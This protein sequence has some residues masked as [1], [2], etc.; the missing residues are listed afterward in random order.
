[1]LTDYVVAELLRMPRRT[2]STM[3]GVTLGVGLF[4]GVLFFVDGLSASMTQRA[5]AP[6][7][8][9]M[10]R[11]V[12]DRAG[13]DLLLTQA[14]EPTEPLTAGQQTAVV[15]EIRND[16]EF[17]ANEVTIRSTPQPA[18]IYVDG[19]AEMDGRPLDDA[20]G[21]PFSRGV[22]QTGLNL[23]R[24]EAGAGHTLTYRVEATE[25]VTPDDNQVRTTFSTRE[26]F[27]PVAA[28]ARATVPLAELAGLIGDIDGVHEANQLSLASLGSDT[29]SSGS[30]LAYGPV[31]IFGFDSAYA[32]ADDTIRI[33]EGDLEPG[34]AVISSEAARDLDIGI[35]DP[36]TAALPDGSTL[37]RTVTGIADLS[38]ARSL[39]TSRRGGD[40]ETFIYTRYSIVVSPIDFAEIVYPAYERAATT[41]GERLRN[42]PIREIDI[43]LDADRLDAD[44]ATA[45]VETTAIAEAVSAVAASQ[46]YLL[47]NISN[48]LHVAADDAEVAKRL[49]VFLG[50]PGGLLGAMLAAYAGTVLAAAQRRE[51]AT[52]RVRGASRRHLLRMLWLRTA[53]ITGVGSAIGL[54]LGYGATAAILGQESLGRA[55]ASSLIRSAIIGAIGGF[56]VTG[57][58]LY[59][60]GRRSI[61]REI[62]EDRARLARRPPLWR[63]ARLDLIIIGLV[64]IGTIVALRADAFAGAAGSVYFGR[65]VELNLRLLVLPIAVWLAGSLL[66]ARILGSV[67]TRTQPQS[68]PRLQRPLSSLYRLSIGRRPWAIGNGAVVVALVVALATCL[69]AFTASYDRAKGRDALYANGSDIRITFRPNSDIVVEPGDA[70]LFLTEGVE[71][72]SPVIYAPSN[73]ILRSARTSDPANLAAVDPA[74]FVTVA[75]LEGTRFIDADA[76]ESLESLDDAPDSI[77]LSEEMADFLKV[78]AGDTLHVLLARAT[79]DQVEIDLV[80]TELFERIP[81]FPDGAD[82]VMSLA[83]H[84][85]AVPNKPPDFVLAS[86]VAPDEQTLERTVSAL[87]RGPGARAPLGIETRISTLARDQSSLA[88]LNIAGLTDLDAGFALGMAV[89]T[90]AIFV[91]GLLLTRRR[92]YVTLRAQGLEARTIR[93]LIGAEAA[94]VASVGAIAGLAV[95]AVMGFYFV[96]ILRPLFVL[97]PG[98][99][100]PPG[101]ASV[102]VLLVMVATLATSVLG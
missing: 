24:L 38:E 28:N 53:L 35:G 19:S 31:R 98:Y 49:F 96:S 29:L 56:L 50:A 15:I 45:V 43:T 84:T 100:L 52:L 55:S 7:A 39:F 34:G 102:P 83:R 3:A 94:T 41:T 40:L 95:G 9:D 76:T 86:T 33:V 101:S 18:L 87:K 88:A 89:I 26:L 30:V 93:L 6:L 81:G 58:A 12:T 10:Q 82:A 27:T 14:F 44:P 42:P 16:S 91:F 61:D 80:V 11:I 51:Q 20:D 71:A 85:E 25:P 17:P 78:E 65:S 8:I 66:A 5:V 74:S 32:E 99:R 92:E 62:N 79:E 22:A 4:C 47:D 48:T 63:R 97:T 69:T 1:M 13:A 72:V 37:V 68:S 70:D 73:V 23:G 57:A 64:V 54:V 36:A 90:I 67:L 77:L 75:P 59:L 21:N 60:T 46:D 2:L